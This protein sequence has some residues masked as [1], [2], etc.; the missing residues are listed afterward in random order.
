MTPDGTRL[1][2]VNTPNGT[3][4]VFYVAGN[5]LALMAEIPVG[6]EPVS[7]SARNDNE[8][9]VVNWLSDSVSV[10]DLS[11]FKVSRSFDVGDEPTDVVFAGQQKELAFICVSGLNAVKVFDPATP[12]T[13]PQVIAINGKQPRALARDAAGTRVFVSIFESGNQTTII[14]EAQVTANGGPP[15]P[16]PAMAAGLPAAPKVSLIVKWNG[17]GWADETGN[18]KWTPLIPYTLADIDLVVIDAQSPTPAVSTLV[19]SVGTHIGNAVFDPANNRLLVAND[20]ARNLVRFEPNLRG[21][22]LSTRLDS[23]SLGGPPNVIASDLNLHIDLNNPSGSD[24]ER[25]LSLAMPGDL[26]RAADGTLYLAATSSA[27]VGVINSQGAVTSRIQVGQGPTGLALNE[28]RNLL[29]VLNRFDESISTVDLATRTQIATSAVGFN[30]E[31]DTVRNGRRFLYDTSVS[32]H[33]DVSCASCHQN[34]HRDGLAWDLGDPQGQMALFG[35]FHPMKGPMTTQSLRGIIGTEPLHWRGDRN[36]LSDFN[37]AFPSLLGSSRLLTSTEM[38]AFTAFVQTLTYPPNPNENLDRTL[39]NPATGPNATRGKDLFNTTPFDKVAINCNVCHNSFNFGTGTSRLIIPAVELGTSQDFKAPQLR[40]MYQKIGMVNAPGEQISGFGFIHDGSTDSL[41]SFLHNPVFTFQNDTQRQ[42]IEQFMLTF[43]T[44]T[45]PAVGL[46]VTVNG[47]NKGTP[48]VTDRVNLLMAQATFPQNCDL[49]VRGIFNGSSRSFLFSGGQFLTDRQGEAAVTLQTLLQAADDGAE[50]TFMGVPVGAGRRSSIDREL[51]GTLDGDQPK[52]NAMDL[53][54]AFVW[55][56]YL[57]FLNRLPDD[58]GLAFWTNE[59][60]SCGAN[61]Q[62]CTDIRRINTS[63]AFFRSIEFQQTGY[64]VERMYKAAYGDAPNAVSTLD[65]THNIVAPV[66]RFSEFI[67][68]VK[69]I[70]SGVVVNQ[71]N[72]Q[73][74]LDDNKNAFSLAFVQRAR[75]T[76]PNSGYP[77]TL[78]P[79]AFVTR[80]A[81]NA[82]VPVNDSDRTKAL[83]EFGGATDTSDLA[84]RAR[85]LREIAE[86]AVVFNQEQNRAFVLMQ[87][88]GYLRRDPNSGQDTDY[89]GYDFWLRKLDQFNGNFIAAEMVKAF[90]ISTEYRRRFGAS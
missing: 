53:A 10:V 46:Q 24:A 2:A 86:N 90:I 7:V 22:F 9:W 61:N 16:S 12:A 56:H 33:G 18:T 54:Q 42:D 76:D 85:A 3:L 88:F 83:N 79:A 64:L 26:V 72:W 5:A 77:T 19:R 51:N 28:S 55:Q 74:Q 29:Y 69:Q 84:A 48:A 41:F 37:Q 14:S 32:A 34:G 25:A 89:S 70:G 82:G 49:V 31:P 58:P 62:S 4:S 20:E 47:S 21:H 43:D 44:G 78:S 80:L 23:I 8:A 73:K 40:G 68:D 59:I 81:D 17:S 71:G 75:F 50:L 45:A 57:D 15:P 36:T 67:P 63:G 1:L 30:P 87:Y 66:V 39:P 35:R 38:S 65:G 13:S 6:L 52:P 60:T 11:R 27:K